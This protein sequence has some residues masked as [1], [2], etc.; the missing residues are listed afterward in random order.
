MARIPEAF[1]DSLVDKLDIVEVVSEY[2]TLK[3]RGSKYVG[4]C[5]FHNEK[6]PSFTV[7]GEQQM[8]YCFGC[9][10]GG[11]IISFLEKKENL[12][13]VET[14][15]EMAKR[16][17]VPMPVVQSGE[18]SVSHELKEQILAANKDAARFYYNMLFEPQGVE[19]LAYLTEHRGLT[20]NIINRFGLGYAPDERDA[21]FRHLTK[22]G[23]SEDV[24]L[25]ANLI[26][27][28]EYAVR[29]N[30]RARVMFPII[31]V[32]GDILG[33]GGRVMDHS[34]PKYL[35]TSDTPVFNKRRNL[36]ALNILRKNRRERAIIG[37]GYM[38]VIA[39]NMAGF[40]YGVASLGTAV[41][42]EQI[43]LLK[44]TTQDIYVC[45]DGDSAGISATHK[46]IDLMKAEGLKPKIISLP[47]GVDPDEFIKENGAEAFKGMMRTARSSIRYLLDE[48]KEQCDMKTEEGRAEYAQKG[49]NII[50]QYAFDAI[51][52]ELYLK[53]VHQESGFSMEALYQNM[54]KKPAS[55]DSRADSAPPVYGVK[56]KFESV[57]ERALVSVLMAHPELTG[58]ARAMLKDEFFCVDAYRK[59]FTYLLAHPEKT[60]AGALVRVF[61]EDEAVSAALS[62][63]AIEHTVFGDPAAFLNDCCLKLHADFLQKQRDALR[64][65]LAQ[66]LSAEEMIPLAGEMAQ[67]DKEI[68][69]LRGR[70]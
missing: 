67:L 42:P 21:L 29:D 51:E 1:I 13:F 49:S 40:D 16:A 61:A 31:A 63:V 26:R 65:K 23:Y 66:P 20:K 50:S 58:Q 57:T 12:T 59:V 2:V 32:N 43:R 18:K 70:V 54:E 27:K 38:D 7:D 15:E 24:L 52:A 17:H 55:P 14:I 34:Q 6:T 5:P 62:A 25:Q 45:Y 48:A 19:G 10:V 9:H 35:N 28:S 8:F 37:E 64:D 68:K 22:L 30:F 36:Y 4:L 44:R 47:P 53:Q 11:N 3:K 69:Q 60:N 39:L 46:V 41:T 56:Q 33:F